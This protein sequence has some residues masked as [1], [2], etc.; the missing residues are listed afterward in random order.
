M[1]KVLLA[2]D[3]PWILAGLQASVD[4]TAEGFEICATASSGVEAEQLARMHR[5][6]FVL[7][8]IRM[9]GCDGLTL[10]K[11]LRQAGCTAMFA[12]ISGYAEFSYA[13]ESIRLGACGYLLKP[14]EEEELL[15]LLRSVREKLREHYERLLFDE[16]EQETGLIASLFPHECWLTTVYG[17]AEPAGAQSAL[18]CRVSRRSRLY[19]SDAPLIRREEDVPSG[20]FAGVCRYRPFADGG[21]SFASEAASCQEA[22]WQG[23]IER[24]RRLFQPSELPHA[25]AQTPPQPLS[26]VREHLSQTT[27]RQLY[28]L[29]LSLQGCPEGLMPDTPEWLLG[30]FESAEQLLSVLDEELHPR[31]ETD[32]EDVS[33]VSYL[34]EHYQEDLTLD[35]VSRELSMSASSVRRMLQRETGKSFQQCLVTLRMERA[36][37]LLKESILSINEVAYSS[38]FHDALYFRRAFKKCFGLTPSEYR[39]RKDEH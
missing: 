22:A 7:A 19:L 26:Y 8:D 15:A 25:P 12:I 10:L 36:C 21:I 11:R 29:Y 18:T 34:A 30:H 5:P 13:Q 20:C 31:E 14:V 27:V 17:D 32:A 3:E 4:W 33:I 2:D 39:A 24:G 6:D 28:A 23:F 37:T 38:G 16:L 35:A 9:P 1:F